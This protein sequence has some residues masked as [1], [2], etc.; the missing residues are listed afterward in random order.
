MQVN[1]GEKV[2]IRLANLGY[3]QHA[4]QLPGIPMR[5][6]GEDA[7]YLVRP[8]ATDLR[9]EAHTIY[10]GPGEARDI[11]FTAPA[12]NASVPSFSDGV[13]SYNR[14]LFAN[15][16]SHKLT[17][18]GV[19]GLGGMLTEVRVYD[20]GPLSPQTEPNQTYA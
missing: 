16:S 8:D 12:Y 17:N 6:V 2:L 5:V 1:P 9:Y 11:L 14:Y 3:E 4:M 15:R 7:T 20:G 10:I 19:P 13:G 18:P